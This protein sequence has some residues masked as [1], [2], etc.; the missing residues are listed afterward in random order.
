LLHGT[1]ED[2]FWLACTVVVITFALAWMFIR[3]RQKTK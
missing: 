1:I 3:H 2:L